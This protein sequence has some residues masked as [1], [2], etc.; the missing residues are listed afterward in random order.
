MGDPGRALRD[1]AQAITNDPHMAEGYYLRGRLLQ[2][3]GDRQAAL[4]DYG[5]ALSLAPDYIE[6][7]YARAQL[8]RSL[9]AGPEAL[10]DFQAI[11]RAAHAGERDAAPVPQRRIAAEV[12][13]LMQA[14]SV[15][16]ARRVLQLQASSFREDSVEELHE[17]ACLYERVDQMDFALDDWERLGRLLLSRQ[18]M[19]QIAVS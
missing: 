11:W 18:G 7:R 15:D 13:Y 1:V 8:Y 12:H 16:K 10:A 9:Q 3:S 19:P 2:R 14:G 17:R 6:A 4:R 5:V